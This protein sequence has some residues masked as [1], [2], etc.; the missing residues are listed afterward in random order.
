MAYIPY[1]VRQVEKTESWRFMFLDVV[2]IVVA[3]AFT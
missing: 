2:V 3:W 1:T